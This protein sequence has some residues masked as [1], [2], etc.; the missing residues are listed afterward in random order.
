MLVDAIVI[1]V[2]ESVAVERNKPSDPDRDFGSHVVS[3]QHRDLR[4]SLGRLNK[5]GFRRVH[6]L[7]G[8]EAQIDSRRDRPRAPVER[9]A[10]TST[11][12]STSS[13]TSTAAPP[14][15]ARCSPRSAGRSRTTGTSGGRRL[16]RRMDGRLSSSATSSTADPDTPGVLRLVMG[17]VEAGT[18]LCVS[19]NHEAKLVR[20]LKG[21]KV[22]V[23]HGLAESLD[24][25]RRPS[26]TTS[27][28]SV[29]WTSWTG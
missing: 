29:L 10:P 2:P 11:G 14:S 21:S 15:S 6:V 25:V 24:A 16:A 12:P 26:R 8:T 23:S 28:S 18:A 19:G 7:R 13:A 1:D 5:E 22:T 4:R 27:A 17:M 3:R 9:P 20:A